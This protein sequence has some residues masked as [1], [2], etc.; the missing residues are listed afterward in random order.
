MHP[1]TFVL[2]FF[3]IAIFF[4]AS[5]ASTAQVSFFTPPTYSG[6]GQQQFSADFN[7]DG[8]RDVLNAD[9]TLQL[10]NGDG[11]FS[12]GTPVPG[13]PLSIGDY[14]GDGKIDVLETGTGTLL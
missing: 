3:C 2:R 13:Q 12:T 8:K 6:N 11:T 14:N 5:I 7:N 4:F 1:A 10:G 9:G